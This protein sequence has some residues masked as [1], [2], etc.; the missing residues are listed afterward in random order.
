MNEKRTARRKVF[1]AIAVAAGIALLALELANP[2]RGTTTGERWF[3]FI[4][5]AL[6]VGLGVAE[7]RS[8]GR[9]KDE[10]PGDVG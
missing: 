8:P 10:G 4:V 9:G 1:A 2:P 5:G 6:L 7:L 3:W